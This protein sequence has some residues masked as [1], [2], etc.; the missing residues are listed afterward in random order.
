MAE[1]LP[2]DL[3]ELEGNL[4]NSGTGDLVL[5]DDL[6][7]SFD[8]GN[9]VVFV[10][11]VIGLGANCIPVNGSSLA[12]VPNDYD[13]PETTYQEWSLSY[14]VI[15]EVLP[16]VLCGGYSTGRSYTSDVWVDSGDDPLYFYFSADIYF[17]RIE[18]NGVMGPPTLAGF[19]QFYSDLHNGIPWF[20]GFME[21]DPI[22]VEVGVPEH[23]AI[24]CTDNQT[25][26]Y[27]NGIP[28]FVAP[29]SARGPG[30]YTFFGSASLGWVTNYL[31]GSCPGN[32]KPEVI[33][34]SIGFWD[35]ALT[36]TQVQSLFNMEPV[37][38]D[39]SESTG[40]YF[41]LVC[42]HDSAEIEELPSGDNLSLEKSSIVNVQSING[43][44]I[45]S[46]SDERKK[47]GIQTIE[48]P[49]S[50]LKNLHGVNFKWKSSGDMSIGLIAQEVE[51]VLPQVI[52]TS[53]SGIKS[54]SY[55]NLVGLLLESVK[56]QTGR[57]DKLKERADRYIHPSANSGFIIHE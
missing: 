55:G 6:G 23:H 46:T 52:T 53:S 25:I 43:Y 10:D 29:W 7:G 50:T 15:P 47:K 41:P 24:V 48:S 45:A 27:R 22:E 9:E 54:V 14:W 51:R 57:I 18:I 37:F 39:P 42:D 44:V 33:F 11:G 34:D 19:M 17:E 5:T 1:I 21:M 36:R 56:D 35:R 26:F 13:P 4:D 31:T 12:I 3:W 8:F 32:P 2:L 38:E 16:D 30:S 40:S 49:I 28:V 20:S